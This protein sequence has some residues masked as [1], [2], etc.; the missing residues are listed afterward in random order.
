MLFHHNTS[1]RF[2]FEDDSISLTFRAHIRFC[3]GKGAGLWLVV[4][5]S[6]CLFCIAHPNFTSMLHFCLGLIQ[7]LASSLFMCECGHRL[8]A[9]DMHL[10]RCLFGGQ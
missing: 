1:F 6:I 4:R 2:I 7:P 3:S 5:P 9:Y 8:D 10:A